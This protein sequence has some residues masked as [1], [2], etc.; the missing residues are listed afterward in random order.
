MNCI[1]LYRK[2]KGNMCGRVEVIF[3][4]FCTLTQHW[5]WN[6]I[7][8][9]LMLRIKAIKGKKRS[10]NKSYKRTFYKEAGAARALWVKGCTSKL[11]GAL[12]PNLRNFSVKSALFYLILEIYGVHVHPVHPP[13]RRPCE[14]ES[15]FP[16]I[17]AR[18]GS[19]KSSF[20]SCFRSAAL[21]RK[22]LV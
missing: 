5:V 18:K 9:L 19:H 16:H 8:K 20:I 7:V 17:I 21:I 4:S 22:C 3:R 10:Q 15:L 11:R 1:I 2:L 13:L 12:R 14:T 6:S